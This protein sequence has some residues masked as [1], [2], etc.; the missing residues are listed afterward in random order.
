[1]SDHR[2]IRALS[3]YQPWAQA[4]TLGLKRYET[5]NWATRYCG[6]LLIHASK[7]WTREEIRF[8]CYAVHRLRAMIGF[9]ERTLAFEENPPLGCIV[10]IA[11]LV[12]CRSTSQGSL[13]LRHDGK[14]TIP[15]LT[16]LELLFGDFGPGRYA[17]QIENVIALPEPVPCKGAQGL[18]GPPAEVLD[19]VASLAKSD[20]PF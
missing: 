8:Q 20:E 18:W 9:D 1:M 11:D 5:R 2:E 19:V 10:A 7:R 6:P 16:E 3:L 13:L 12:E 17:W 14:L 15:G 4:I